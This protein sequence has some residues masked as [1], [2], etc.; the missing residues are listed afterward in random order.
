MAVQ[1]SPVLPQTPKLNLT[2]FTTGSAAGTFVN[3]YTGGTNGSKVTGV[4][5]TNTSSA[6]I[7]LQ[8]A[9]S[10]TASG[11]LVNYNI[12][13]ATLVSSAGSDG[14]DAPVSLMSNATFPVDGDGNPYLF[15]TS[16]LQILTVTIATSVPGATTAKAVNVIAVGADF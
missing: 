6:S 9:I 11:A 10:S 4:S 15:L 3:L 8:L 1:S 16:S 5:A 7:V 12:N 13:S 2:Q 14:S